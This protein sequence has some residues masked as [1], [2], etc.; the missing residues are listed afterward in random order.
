MIIVLG[1]PEKA[2]NRCAAGVAAVLVIG[3]PCWWSRPTTRDANGRTAKSH[4]VGF[5]ASLLSNLA[6]LASHLSRRDLFEL[7][8]SRDQGAWSHAV[9]SPKD[10]N[11]QEKT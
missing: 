2:V 11:S 1:P 4:I 3:T 9:K 6:N 10:G 7:H 5:V 8:A